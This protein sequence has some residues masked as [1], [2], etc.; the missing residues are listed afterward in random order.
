MPKKTK[1]RHRRSKYETHRYCSYC[2]YWEP[3]S[4]G[5]LR[6]PYCSRTLR[7]TPRSNPHRQRILKQREAAILERIKQQNA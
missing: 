4:S 6:C 1:R 2:M 3:R 5:K 7:D